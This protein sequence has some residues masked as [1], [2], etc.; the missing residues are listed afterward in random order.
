MKPIALSAGE[1]LSEEAREKARQEHTAL[2]Q[3]FRRW[4]ADYV[5]RRPALNAPCGPSMSSVRR[6][7][8]VA[9]SSREMR[10]SREVK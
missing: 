3:Q 4:L 1:R 7:G 6:C 9:G 10:S 8:P 5:G 2:N